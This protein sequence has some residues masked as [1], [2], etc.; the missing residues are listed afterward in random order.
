VALTILYVIYFGLALYSFVA[1]SWLQLLYTYILFYFLLEFTMSLFIHRWATH[2]LWNPPVWFQNIMSVVSLTAMIGTP[3]SYSAWHRNH[4]KHSDTDRDPHSPK[5]S[6]W[7][8]IIF[9]T[10]EQDYD[11]SLATDRLRNRWQLFLTKYETMLVYMLNA[12][13]F[14][15]LPTVWFLTW[16]TAVAMTTFWVMLVTGIMCHTDEVR[17]VPYMYPFAFSES[18]HRQHHIKPN[19]THCWFDPCVW[20]VKRLGWT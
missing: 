6:S 12:I 4:H 16:A 3:I 2:N 13:L 1:L 19:L 8:Y 15:V 11:L 5:H 20:L 14:L 17:D 7:L 10:H 9:R 18:F